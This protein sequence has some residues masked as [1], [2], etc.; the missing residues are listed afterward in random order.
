M[1]TN[2]NSPVIDNTPRIRRVIQAV[3]DL[4]SQSLAGLRILDLGCAHGGYAIE[5]ARRGAQVVGIEAR[6]AWLDQARRS[7]QDAG[8]TN[9]EFIQDDVRNLSKDKYGEFD[10][11]LC[12]GILYHLDAP[13]VF[14][15]LIRMAEVCQNFSI[16]D[17]H[18]ATTAELSREWRDRH[19]WGASYKE[20]KA[21]MTLQEKLKVMG[22]SLDN[23]KSFWFTRSSL[24]N[25][26]RHVGFTSVY[27]CRNPV[28][29]M[30]V[31]GKFKIF[32]DR[33]T[34][35][36]IKGEP[37]TLYGGPQGGTPAE[38]DWPEKLEDHFFQR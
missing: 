5:F 29:N 8:L 7:K 12:L 27:E 28:D 31:D 13:D 22:A 25:V 24:C 38:E 14:D 20:H 19:Y 17:T 32:H 21:G 23:E 33:V 6:E 16:I 37:V 9:V 18:V 30:Y 2:T 35:A 3:C 11:I 15:F 10:I 34:L 26:L 36:A 1:T 4:A